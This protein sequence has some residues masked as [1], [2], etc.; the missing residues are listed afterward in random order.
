[1]GLLELG[2]TGEGV[3]AG[4]CG[5]ARGDCGTEGSGELRFGVGGLG[6]GD[7]ALIG[8]SGVFPVLFSNYSVSVRINKK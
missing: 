1:M 8:G 6:E 4:E 3:T 5:R 2:G 7:G